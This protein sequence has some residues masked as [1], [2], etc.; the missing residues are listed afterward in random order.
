MTAKPLLF[1]IDGAGRKG[2]GASLLRDIQVIGFLIACLWLFELLLL[3]FRQVAED[4]VRR[5]LR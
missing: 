2:A 1:D 5:L 3:F 4:R